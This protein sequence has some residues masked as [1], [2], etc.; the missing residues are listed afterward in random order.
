MGLGELLTVSSRLPIESMKLTKTKRPFFLQS[1][2]LVYACRQIPEPS[3]LDRGQQRSLE[4][5][6]LVIEDFSGT[7]TW[8]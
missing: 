5:Y 1:L 7:L 4:E 3:R 8:S 6:D 2:T